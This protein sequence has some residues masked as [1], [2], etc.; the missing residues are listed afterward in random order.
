MN[1]K[2]RELNINIDNP[3]FNKIDNKLRKVLIDKKFNSKFRISIINQ[4]KIDFNNSMNKAIKANVQ[5]K[6]FSSE[7]KSYGLLA[8]VMTEKSMFLSNQGLKN[9]V[10]FFVDRRM[11]KTAI[12]AEVEKMFKV[13][14]FSVHTITTGGTCSDRGKLRRKMGEGLQKKAVITLKKGDNIFLGEL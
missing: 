9:K 3:T 5:K 1:I 7:K 8:P 13:S 2:A 10:V 4:K 14:V 11:T 12:K 6:K